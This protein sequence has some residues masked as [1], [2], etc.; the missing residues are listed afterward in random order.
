MELYVVPFV[1]DGMGSN[2]KTSTTAQTLSVVFRMF[3]F[4]GRPSNFSTPQILWKT[5]QSHMYTNYESLGYVCPQLF[6]LNRAEVKDQGA[7][8]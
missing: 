7:Q 8:L 5:A 3:A 4:N 1:L 2:Y 6:T